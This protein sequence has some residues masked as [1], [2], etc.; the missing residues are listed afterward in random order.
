MARITA[1][2]DR[3]CALADPTGGPEVI[4]LAPIGLG[5]AIVAGTLDPPVALS[6]FCFVVRIFSDGDA[7]GP[8]LASLEKFAQAGATQLRWSDGSELPGGV[9]PGATTLRDFLG[10][11]E[12]QNPTA[13]IFS[14]SIDTFDDRAISFVAQAAKLGCD[15]ATFDFDYDLNYD[16]APQRVFTPSWNL[17]YAMGV[18]YAGEFFALSPRAM[19]SLADSG[20][21][22]ADLGSATSAGLNLEALAGEF[23]AIRIPAVLSH[24]GERRI[25]VDP[26]AQFGSGAAAGLKAS[27]A[28]A[29]MLGVPIE[30]RPTDEPGRRE[31][32]YGDLIKPPS[33][34]V[35]IPT[36]DR[37]DLL[38]GVIEGLLERTAYPNL[39]V[40]V[41]DN[42]SIQAKTKGY[43]EVLEMRGAA[44]HRYHGEFN[45]AAMH[46]EVLAELT[47]EYF[48]LLNNDV[49]IEDPRWLASAMA[50]A[51]RADVG[52]VGAKLL[53]PDRT[54]QHAGIMIGGNGETSH[55]MKG[56]AGDDVG[57]GF[58][59]A[60]TS[61]VM[62]VTG[63]AMVTRASVFKE[64]GGFDAANF[65]VSFNDIDYCL[66][67]RKAGYRVLFNPGVTLFHFES[68]SRGLDS[69]N[70]AN[71]ARHRRELGA[72]RAK[73]GDDFGA[74]PYFNP[75]LDPYDPCFGSL[76]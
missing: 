13:Y 62:A 19:A 2:C 40:V 42:D 16:V 70:E 60:V 68:K 21:E 51:V 35:V 43:L 25:A 15:F 33:V 74:D 41:I 69:M 58:R 27:R 65:A 63:A 1:S 37:I 55:Y 11:N 10:G 26:V 29:G 38:A 46:N 61:E 7:F 12:N 22:I 56:I 28:V 31:V 20:L 57:Y 23:I 18:D 32:T 67:V 47:S 9:M 73:W 66:A 5:P 44:I 48:C 50:L 53:Y 4:K 3:R 45:F 49:F 76:A 6:E 59:S 24:N 8:G 64:V 71:A 75:Q 30:I 52:V 36:R 39:Q 54:V 14:R 17:D 72:M 34:A